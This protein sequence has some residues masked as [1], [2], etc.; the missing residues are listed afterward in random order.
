MKGEWSYSRVTKGKEGRE[1]NVKEE[2]VGGGQA[3]RVSTCMIN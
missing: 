1:A 2:A 3:G